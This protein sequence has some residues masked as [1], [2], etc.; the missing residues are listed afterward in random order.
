MKT[1]T[2]TIRDEDTKDRILWFLKHL[3]NEGVEIM[4][5]E[6]IED[7][8]LLAKTRGEESIPYSEYLAN[9]H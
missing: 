9:E 2:I 8:K 4:L 3:E 1:V 5:Q 6:D 7:L